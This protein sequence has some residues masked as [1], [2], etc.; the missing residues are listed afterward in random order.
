MAT[1]VLISLG[2]TLPIFSA[3]IPPELNGG[4]YI[5]DLRFITLE[6]QDLRVTELLDGA[7]DLHTGYIDPVHYPVLNSDPDIDVFRFLRN[8][9]GKMLINCRDYPL[10]IT[11][12][13]RAFAFAFDKVLENDDILDGFGQEHDS[14]LPY[15]NPWCIED[16]FDYHYYMADSASGN[17]ILD[18]LGFDIDPVSGFRLA[19][20]GTPF[21]IDIS[22]FGAA[23]IAGGSAAIARDAFHSLHIDAVATCRDYSSFMEV[24]NNHGTYD[25]LFLGN[26]WFDYDVSWLVD[27]F[28]SENAAIY[29]K[30][31]SNFRNASFDMW[32][33]QMLFGKSYDEVAE[34][35]AQMQQILHYNVPE[36]VI[37]QNE[38]LRA[39]RTDQFTG[40]VEDQFFSLVSPW[41]LRSIRKL[42]GS[43]GGTVNIALGYEP[44]TF[45]IYDSGYG[46]YSELLYGG[47][48]SILQN[49]YSSLY[50]YG[51][52]NIIYPDLA[53]ETVIET[54][55]TNPNIPDGHMRFTID[56]VHNAT[57]SDRTP[58]TGRDIAFTFNYAIETNNT[59]NQDLNHL[60]SAYSP[61]PY[62][63]VFE[64]D[65][66]SYWCF[67]KFAFTPIIPYHIFRDDVGIGYDGLTSW[68][69]VYDTE[70]PLVTSGP[71]Q[72][73][74]MT[75]VYDMY[76]HHTVPCYELVRNPYWHYALDHTPQTTQTQ[77]TNSTT[78]Q[79]TS[80]GQPT[81]WVRLGFGATMGLCSVVIVFVLVRLM[82][83]KRSVAA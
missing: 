13:R 37:Y 70:S 2:L 56:I 50:I 40:L 39:A 69:P 79:T 1:A 62:R 19:P 60:V 53:Q 68:N 42:D 57:W 16:E 43:L 27:E 5:D 55:D 36:L 51:P 17:V 21:Q 44:S 76:Y 24:I 59:L 6:N 26:Q 41:N 12:L 66:E 23:I 71:F 82:E 64:F 47:A 33:N 81:D 35:V 4:V 65:S 67:Q 20:N 54:T 22:Y 77:T 8:G 49:M 14:L 25:I 48:P 80:T 32:A 75:E 34:A 7:M 31:P 10:N 61:G 45:N 29:G 58:L 83:R 28:G 3:T 74:Q 18:G 46:S 11:G 38:R 63:V 15:C 73:V 72:F 52:N 9:Y 78:S 30:N